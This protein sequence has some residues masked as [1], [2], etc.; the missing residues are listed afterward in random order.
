VQE[1]GRQFGA[2]RPAH[3]LDVVEI[4]AAVGELVGARQWRRALR[5]IEGDDLVRSISPASSRSAACSSGGARAAQSSSAAC[6]LG[7]MRGTSTARD[8]SLA[9]TTSR[10]SRPGPFSVASFTG[11]ALPIA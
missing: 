2:A 4:G 8:R 1:G 11:R 7:T 10:P 6:R 3:K 5:R 9:T